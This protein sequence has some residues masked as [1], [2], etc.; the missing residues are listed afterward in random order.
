MKLF[1]QN[2]DHNIDPLSD[3]KLFDTDYLYHSEKSVK[4]KKFITSPADIEVQCKVN[5][6]D[7]MVP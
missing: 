7:S 2:K 5:L 3:T 4:E 1:F 6:R